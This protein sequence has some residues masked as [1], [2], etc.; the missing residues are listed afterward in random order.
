ME[1]ELR[2]LNLRS[3]TFD[4]IYTSE[5]KLAPLDSCHHE[6]GCHVHLLIAHHIWTA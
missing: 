5:E 3:Q 1:M 6:S 2:A 4:Y